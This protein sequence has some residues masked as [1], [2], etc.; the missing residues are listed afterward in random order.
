MKK[1]KLIAVFISLFM[2]ISLIAGCAKKEETKPAE[3]SDE[4]KA[5]E[6]EEVKEPAE[7]TKEVEETKEPEKEPEPE[8]K[9]ITIVDMKGR[10]IT[11]AEP[12]TRIVALTPSDCEI[13]YAI[14]A[15][16]TV[17][18]RGEYCNYPEEV[19]LLPAV[20]SGA[21][22]NLEQII[23]L[24][25]QVLLMNT[26]A[27]SKEQ[28]EILEEAGIKVVVSDAK[29]IEGVYTSISLISTITGK[30]EEGSAVISNMEETFVEV[31]A[32]AEDLGDKTVYFEVSPL[33]YGLWTAGNGTFM[34][35]IANMIGVK[36][37]FADVQGW[38]E[39]SEEQVLERDP[40]YIV[41]IAMYFGEGPEPVDEILGRNGWGDLKAVKAKAILNLQN[42][43][44]SRPGPRLADGAKMLFEFIKA[45]EEALANAA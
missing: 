11:L 25:P 16:D 27:Q 1:T 8:D 3:T 19:L 33:E 39:V 26:M 38:S 40:D 20:E 6:T 4:A 31:S 17:V 7:E 45:L 10:E 9:S 32:L 43:E 37:C 44:F 30:E 28:V 12:A 42:D 13:L 21:N 2:L 35:E 24:E 36:N 34:E 18:G 22:T 41:T 15:G 23:E 14:G 5:T 29:D